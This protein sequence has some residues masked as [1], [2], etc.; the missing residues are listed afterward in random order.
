M[1]CH[2]V[3]YIYSTDDDDVYVC[4][5]KGNINLYKILMS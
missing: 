1:S 2:Y 4:R 5:L 3:S